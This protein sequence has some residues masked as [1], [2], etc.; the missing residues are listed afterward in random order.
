MSLL[1]HLRFSADN[2][3]IINI[4]LTE[5]SEFKLSSITLK[6]PFDVTPTAFCNSQYRS[7]IKK[8][9]DLSPKII[10]KKRNSFIP[11]TLYANSANPPPLLTDNQL[12]TFATPPP[13]FITGCKYLWHLAIKNWLRNNK[14]DSKKT[15]NFGIKT[16]RKKKDNFKRTNK[17]WQ[18]TPWL[19]AELLIYN[20]MQI[21]RTS[22]AGL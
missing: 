9:D 19:S 8:W 6:L 13:P 16:K 7:F 2:T 3:L 14:T 12:T 17:T 4:Q 18:K 1:C 10:K 20:A 11:E 15:M 5:N 22:T 21:R